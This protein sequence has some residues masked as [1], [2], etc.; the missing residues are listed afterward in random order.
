[1]S[2]AFAGLLELCL[3]QRCPACGADAQPEG[4][5]CG[6]CAQDVP[7]MRARLCLRCARRGCDAGACATHPGHDVWSAWVWDERVAE[8]I[9]ALKYGGQTRVVAALSDEMALALAGRRADLVTEVP[10]HPA[11]ERERGYNQAALLARA[12]SVRIGVPWVP[13]VL[14]R[15]RPTPTQTTLGPRARAANLAGAFAVAER[16]WVAGRMVLLVDD[17][18]TTGATLGECSDALRAAGARVTCATLSWVQ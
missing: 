10:L 13:S 2:G 4:V 15:V 16:A 12:L 17:V 3:G 8:V 11:R 18:F 14:R 1:M 7:R 5:L 6:P 9:H